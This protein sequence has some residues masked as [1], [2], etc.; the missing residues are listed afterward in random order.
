M[1]FDATIDPL[2]ESNAGKGITDSSVQQI[3][4]PIDEEGVERLDDDVMWNGN[5]KASHMEEP[6]G[7]YIVGSVVASLL[8]GKDASQGSNRKRVL[9]PKPGTPTAGDWLLVHGGGECYDTP[10]PEW[11]QETNSSAMFAQSS[12][13]SSSNAISSKVRFS[14][15]NIILKRWV[16]LISLVT[17]SGPVFVR[18]RS[19]NLLSSLPTLQRRDSEHSHGI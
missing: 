1:E 15:L 3:M 7:G 6:D 10:I 13:S 9:M 5:D 12:S 4:R 17:A 16:W 2:R 19:T 18:V 14:L 11:L 8:Y